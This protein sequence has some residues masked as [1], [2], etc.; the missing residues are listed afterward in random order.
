MVLCL[1]NPLKTGK[2][3][4]LRT[5]D[6]YHYASSREETYLQDFINHMFTIRIPRKHHQC[7]IYVAN[8]KMEIIF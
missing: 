4:W 6:I 1:M 5:S 3:L 7:V 8:M 2:T